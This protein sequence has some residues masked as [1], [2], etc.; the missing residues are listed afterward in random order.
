MN[1]NRMLLGLGIAAAVSLLTS[2]LIFRQLKRASATPT[3]APTGHIVVA[4]HAL[5][6]GARL[7]D[8]DLSLVPWPSGSPMA[9]TFTRKEECVNRA[10]TTALAENEPVMETKLAPKDGGAG[11]TVAIPEGMRAVSV[12]VNEVVDVSGFVLPGTMVD[13]V[14]TATLTQGQ[15]EPVTRTILENVRVLAAGQKIEQ[16]REGKPQTVAVITL[17]VDPAQADKL[18]MAA[19]QGKIQLALRNTI[20]TKLV[21]P[22]PVYLS[23]LFGGEGPKKA[24]APTRAA[25]PAAPPPYEIE[26]ISGDK[27]ETKGFPGGGQK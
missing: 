2:M 26:V 11:L 17:L 25:K 8:S 7:T 19:T 23:S 3:A 18:A 22:P 14:A 12:A 6:L 24:A 4:A 1:R 13:V 20:D 16:D 21:T 27:K 9:G 5:P 10:I 15:S